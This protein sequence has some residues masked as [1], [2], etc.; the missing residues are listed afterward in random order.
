[1]I[2]WKVNNPDWNIIE[3]NNSNLKNYINLEKEIPNFNFKKISKASLSDIIRIFILER[4]GGLWC[5]ATTLNTQSINNFLNQ[6]SGDFFAFSFKHYED[7]MIS[8]WFLY[9]KKGSYIIKKWKQETISYIS[10]LNK[11]GGNI[12]NTYHIWKNNKYEYEHYFWFHYLFT[13]LYKN[14]IKFKNEWDNSKKIYNNYSHH[15]MNK[16]NQKINSDDFNMIEDKNNYLF[17]LT[18]RNNVNNKSSVLDFFYT[19]YDLKVINISCNLSKC[20]LDILKRNEI[21]TKNINGYF[22]KVCIIRNPYERIIEY[23]YK[24]KKSD[25]SIS[26]LNNFILNE[27]DEN[28]LLEQSNYLKYCDIAISY[29]NLESN[30]NYILR[31]FDKNEI[32]FNDNFKE[33]EEANLSQICKYKIQRLYYNDFILWKNLKTRN[34]IFKN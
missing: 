26:N 25:Y 24:N 19:K 32:K 28:S 13:D 16:L 10:K 33:L 1:M 18:Y 6:I 8:S 4:Y 2:S 22:Y 9:A 31:L 15:F 5:D 3:L 14:D 12:S 34:I 11:I 7:R 27:L 23:F 20:H 17:K 21:F 29:N 30:L